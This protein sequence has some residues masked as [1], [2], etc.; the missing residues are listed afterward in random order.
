MSTSTTAYQDNIMDALPKTYSKASQS[1]RHRVHSKGSLGQKHAC[2]QRTQINN[3]SAYTAIKL[4]SRRA[5]PT[6]G[7][8]THGLIMMPSRQ[9]QLASHQHDSLHSVQISQVMRFCGRNDM[10]S[11]K[12]QH[13]QILATWKQGSCC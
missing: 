2:S 5:S 3:S 8:Q 13:I 6:K 4:G 7:F 9:D 12:P 1:T 10:K 11:E